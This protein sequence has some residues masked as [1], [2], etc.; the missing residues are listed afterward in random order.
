M[1]IAIYIH[2]ELSQAILDAGADGA[3]VVGRLS[4]LA[5]ETTQKHGRDIV[6]ATLGLPDG[7]LCAMSVTPARSGLIVEIDPP[8]LA[9]KRVGVVRN[10][11]R[12]PI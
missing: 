11:G 8:A 2:P 1:R 10:S 3:R 12:R 9:L 5:I 6:Y 4:R 7:K